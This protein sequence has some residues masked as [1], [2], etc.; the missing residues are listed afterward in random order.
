[1][2]R[3]K[4]YNTIYK[5]NWLGCPIYCTVQAAP[6]EGGMEKNLYGKYLYEPRIVVEFTLGSQSY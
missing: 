6:I 4:F 2:W 1:M 5:L 3:H